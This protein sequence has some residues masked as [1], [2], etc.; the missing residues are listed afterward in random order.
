MKLFL[1]VLY[2]KGTRNDALE[3]PTKRVLLKRI[4]ASSSFA[5][6][7]ANASQEP[8]AAC[9]SDGFLLSFL[10]FILYVK[11]LVWG[12]ADL[13]Y[14]AWHLEDGRNSTLIRCQL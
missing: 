5:H 9:Q 4:L 2:N 11:C 3:I 10:K 8:P 14:F 12:V 6:S 7:N 1:D 13:L